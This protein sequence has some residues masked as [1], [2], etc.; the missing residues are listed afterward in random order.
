MRENIQNLPPARVA[1]CQNRSW[2]ASLGQV[3]AVSVVMQR[4][5]SA[6]RPGRGSRIGERDIG[7]SGATSC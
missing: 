4:I 5:R 3:Q 6:G 2:K 7:S 1:T